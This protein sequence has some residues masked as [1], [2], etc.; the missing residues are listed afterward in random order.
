MLLG[1]V[2]LGYLPGTFLARRSVDGGARRFLMA[3]PLAA[4]AAVAVFGSA[5]PAVGVSAGLLAALAFIAGMRTIAGSAFGLNAAPHAKVAIMGARA[6]AIQ[7]GYLFGSLLGGVAL[8]FGGFPALGATLA[9]LFALA[10]VP[11]VAA[12]LR[13]RS[14]AVA[15]GPAVASRAGSCL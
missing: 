8:A 15:V 12:A 6:A 13:E 3:L 11:H 1:A 14:A 7:G 9:T 4:A 2:A 5:R 10:A